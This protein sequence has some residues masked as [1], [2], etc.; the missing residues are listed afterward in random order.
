MR[1]KKTK[2]LHFRISE[3]DFNEIRK[4]A[5]KFQS[6]SHFVISAIKDFGDAT[7]REKMYACSRLSEYYSST[8]QKLAHIGGNLNQAMKRVNEAAKVAHPTQALILEG[9]IP[10]IRECSNICLDL[11]KELRSITC[12]VIK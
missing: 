1:H 8:D 6:V 2:Q 9:L 5:S 7:I 12:K 10:E 3:D 11:R 4:R